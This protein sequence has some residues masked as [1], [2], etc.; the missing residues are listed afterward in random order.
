MRERAGVA[1]H[2]A[3]GLRRRRARCSW[4][5]GSSG[6]TEERH[7]RRE[8]LLDAGGGFG[9]VLGERQAHGA[10]GCGWAPKA[11][12]RR[13]GNCRHA[14]KSQ[15][16]AVDPGLHREHTRRFPRTKVVPAS[17]ISLRP[18]WVALEHTQ[19]LWVG[20]RSEGAVD[21]DRVVPAR[22]QSSRAAWRRQLVAAGPST[23]GCWG[24]RQRHAG[25]VDAWSRRH[26]RRG[27]ADEHGNPGPARCR[28]RIRG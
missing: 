24:R 3:W 22:P 15:H 13:G 19:R 4:L 7:E 20:L 8:E 21:V 18:S 12:G 10:G 27:V 26:G 16:R 5:E 17:V 9:S 6:L 25:K 28:R 14:V 1:R 2:R 11:G 23:T